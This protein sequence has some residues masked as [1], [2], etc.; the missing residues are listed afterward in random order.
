MKI[1]KKQ[2]I[3]FLFFIFSILILIFLLFSL[4]FFNLNKDE[5]TLI[6]IKIIVFSMLFY[7]IFFITMVIDFFSEVYFAV[8]EMKKNFHEN[9]PKLFNFLISKKIK[10]FLFLIIVFLVWN[11]SIYLKNLSDSILITFLLFI[12]ER[13][14]NNKEKYIIENILRAFLYVICIYLSSH[15][16]EDEP[17]FK[18]WFNQ[19]S[20][21]ESDYMFFLSIVRAIFYVKFYLCIERAIRPIVKKFFNKNNVCNRS[22]N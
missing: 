4:Y 8:D 12:A 1:S 18:F 19:I 9:F 15:F 7:L 13:L 10:L 3:L 14:T 20:I 16:I 22:Q 6:F 5:K 11:F 21:P 17:K 2:K